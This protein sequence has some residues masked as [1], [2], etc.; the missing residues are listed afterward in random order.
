MSG[1]LSFVEGGQQRRRGEGVRSQP[2]IVSIHRVKRLGDAPYLLLNALPCM[3]LTVEDL[4]SRVTVG[5]EPE[6]FDQPRW[7]SVQTHRRLNSHH[8][9]GQPPCPG[10]TLLLRQLPEDTVRFNGRSLVQRRRLTVWRGALRRQWGAANGQI[11]T[12]LRCGIITIGLILAHFQTRLRTAGWRLGRRM[13]GLLAGIIRPL[14][15][16]FCAVSRR[17]LARGHRIERCFPSFTCANW[18]SCHRIVGLGSDLWR[19]W[20]IRDKFFRCL[21]RL[22]LRWRGIAIFFSRLRIVQHR[23]FIR[24]LQ[25]LDRPGEQRMQSVTGI[26]HTWGR[27]CDLPILALLC[28]LPQL[29]EELPK[30]SHDPND[31]GGILLTPHLIFGH[32]PFKEPPQPVLRK[33]ALPARSQIIYRCDHLARHAALTSQSHE[34][35]G[36]VFSPPNILLSKPNL[37]ELGYCICQCFAPANITHM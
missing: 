2:R 37:R 36:A 5:G 17:L 19:L 32:F 34:M 15:C 27:L 9:F 22:Y 24:H 12:G 20:R 13:C 7:Q 14:E 21:L 10:P 4:A 33:F 28:E 26:G 18:H 11:P 23:L 16:L 30:F 8:C 29:F 35:L 1:G 6:R 25:H 31:L 3:P